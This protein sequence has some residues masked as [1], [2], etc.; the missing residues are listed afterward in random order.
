[1]QEA[2]L[3]L[4]KGDWVSH[5]RMPGWGYG[6]ILEL[7]GSNKGRVFFL[8]AGEKKISWEHAGLVP[9]KN[10]NAS[11]AAL[12]G[13]LAEFKMSLAIDLLTTVEPGDGVACIACNTPGSTCELCKSP[14]ESLRNYSLA[15]KGK[16]SICDACRD[17]IMLENGDR[18]R[19]NE[20]IAKM[21]ERGKKDI[22]AKVPKKKLKIVKK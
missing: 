2:E 11:Q 13:Q 7:M 15:H 12:S 22:T 19:M 1:M 3:R 17:K 8:F 9:V 14:S 10:D 20:S 6:K 18:V 21:E 16:M 4:C 5:P